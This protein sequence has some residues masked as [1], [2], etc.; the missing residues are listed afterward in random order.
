M[1]LN[2][3]FAAIET[4]EFQV[5]YSICSGFRSVLDNMAKDELLSKLCDELR[6]CPDTCSSVLQ[7]IRALLQAHAND[8]DTPIDE[9]VAAY[10]VLPWT[11]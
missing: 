5:Q 11:S 4:I 3:Y 8:G 7:R 1:I 2:K 10:F 6:N 9:S